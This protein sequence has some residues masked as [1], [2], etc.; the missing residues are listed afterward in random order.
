MHSL[1][2]TWSISGMSWRIDRN[3]LWNDRAIDLNVK[4]CKRKWDAVKER[5]E[6]IA[7]GNFTKMMI[8]AECWLPLEK[9]HIHDQ[10]KYRLDV[11]TASACTIFYFCMLQFSR[12]NNFHNPRKAYHFDI[13]VRRLFT[14]EICNCYANRNYRCCHCASQIVSPRFF[15]LIRLMCSHICIQQTIKQ[16]TT[17]TTNTQLYSPAHSHT[18]TFIHFT[19][20]TY[21]LSEMEFKWNKKKWTTT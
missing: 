2:L 4:W 17:H 7:T 9:M 16:L 21:S 15:N 3:Q 19:V 11:A 10:R 20:H 5:D 8:F 13:F 1:G 18:H 6:V 12:H 14:F